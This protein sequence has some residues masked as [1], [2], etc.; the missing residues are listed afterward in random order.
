MSSETHV[1]AQMLLGG[2]LPPTPPEPCVLVL[3]GASGD[4]AHRMVVPALFR[5][6]RRGLL[7]PGFQLVGYARTPMTGDEY[8]AA[9][10]ASVLAQALPG[11]AEAW[12]AFAA[13]ISYLAAQYAGDDEGYQRLAGEL[14]RCDA[15]G[16]GGRRLFYLATPPDTFAPIVRH[17]SAVGLIGHGYTP[18]AGGWSRVIVEKPFGRDAASARALNVAIAQDIEEHSV[19]R[20]DHYLGKEAA[21]NLFA[22]RFANGIFEP[23]WNRNFVDHVQITAAEPLGLEGRAGYYERA[24]AL[25]DMIQNHLLQLMALVAIEPPSA[26]NST[27]VRNEKVKVLRAVRR[28]GEAEVTRM[29][30]RGQYGAGE[31][32]GTR[33]P[34]YREEAGVA[35]AS[36]T[37]TYAALALYIDNWR[38][39]GVPFYLRAG[40]RLTARRTEI[41]VQFKPAP[42][43]PFP[44]PE[45]SG[46][47]NTR[48]VE[49]APQER[50]TL[51]AAG[52]L[53]G[54]GMHVAPLALDYCPACLPGAQATPSAYE[55]LLLDAMRGDPTFFARADEV[56]ASWA[57]IEPVLRAWASEP[58]VGFPNY[59]AGTHG[60]SQADALL[61]REG[62]VWRPLRRDLLPPGDRPVTHP[63]PAYMIGLGRKRAMGQSVARRIARGYAMLAASLFLVVVMTIV[64]AIVAQRA[65]SDMADV[66]IPR[67]RQTRALITAIDHLRLAEIRFVNQPASL[68]ANRRLVS[69]QL[70]EVSRLI[71]TLSDLER[72]PSEQAQVAD[73]VER[74]ERFRDSDAAILTALEAGRRQEASRLLRAAMPNSEAMRVDAERY[75]DVYLDRIDAARAAADR[76]IRGAVA[77]AIALALASALIEVVAPLLELRAAMDALSRG[78]AALAS[79]PDAARTLELKALQDGYNRMAAQIRHDA[80]AL[81]AARDR[82]EERVAEQTAELSEAKTH[83]ER[84]VA[85]LRALDKMKSD[86]MAVMSHE[87]LTPINFI[88]GFGSVLEDEL[89]GPLTDAQRD[90]VAKLMAGADRL[91]RMVRNTLEYT[92]AL[93]GELTV[94]PAEVDYAALVAGVAGDL[95]PR[96]EAKHQPLTVEVAADLP[97]V[98]ADGERAAQVLAELIGNASEFAPAG[99][100]IVVRVSA[101]AGTVTTE[102]ADRGP[103]IAEAAIPHLFEPFFQVDSTSTREHG[104]MGLGLPIARHLVGAMGGTLVAASRPGDG[105]RLWFT[106]PEAVPPAPTPHRSESSTP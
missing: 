19:Y 49:F 105:T 85:E 78:G 29:A 94:M 47:A 22:F 41:A 50:L 97:P 20:I 35:T 7:P 56:E 37:E 38:W 5:L 101:D 91:T 88:V 67:I 89:L 1:D 60:P 11:D 14:V 80:E 103:G 3:F 31:L 57:I 54:Q 87:L 63:P 70:D 104:G 74:F 99:T 59:A 83:L 69:R 45:G 76:A 48:V 33:V 106:L 95:G 36:A 82:L 17:L 73:L 21:Q 86:F 34:G 71:A 75:S 65:G 92:K 32:A 42:H 6:W 2:A 55:N 28:Y 81:E 61:A 15:E 90:A 25:R 51:R 62:R 53:P 93:S 44:V 4:L 13:A 26:W 8:R 77:L 98:R 100:P 30:V 16:T 66:S 43:T 27:A 68:D 10:Q 79:H 40:K 102:V 23:V 46:G 39:A 9:M 52:K 18:P 58:A 84:L 12:P 72:G 24:G 96:L 64:A